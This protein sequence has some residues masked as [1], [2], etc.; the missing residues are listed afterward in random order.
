MSRT[1]LSALWTTAAWRE[2]ARVRA[3]E[4]DVEHL[5]LGLIAVGGAAAA[6][7]GRH[8]ITLASARGR[9]RDA[10]AEDLAT[11]GIDVADLPS[12]IHFMQMGDPAWHATARADALLKSVTLTDTYAALVA[13]LQEPSGIVRRLVHADGV[14]PQDLVPELKEGADDPYAPEAVPADD[15]LLPPPN[16]GQR[17]RRYVSAPPA[18]VVAALADP[19]LLALWAFDPVKSQVSEGGLRNRIEKGGR[20]LTVRLSCTRTTEAD[21]KVVTWVHTAEDTKYAGETL[22]YDR[23]EVRPA[24]GGSEVTRIAGRRTF[25]LVGR[26]LAPVYDLFGSWGLLH[27]MQAITFGIADRQP[28]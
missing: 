22:T 23:F 19:A 13:L 1:Q 18:D 15:T 28:S 9:V 10:L 11:L 20:S 6:L 12:P 8:G 16:R 7:L 5:Y 17:V 4:V 21:A 24:P 25:G 14:V 27:T 26:V 2:A 3:A